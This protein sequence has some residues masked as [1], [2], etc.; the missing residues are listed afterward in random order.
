MKSSSV[1]VSLLFVFAIATLP[2]TSNAAPMSSS[3]SLNGGNGMQQQQN[4]PHYNNMYPSSSEGGQFQF[5]QYGPYQQQQE[6][7]LQK[8]WSRLEPSIR[9]FKR[10]PP[11]Q[12]QYQP[13][14]I[15]NNEFANR[16]MLY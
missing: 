15:N 1:I 5:A 11:Q 10:S 2:F 8:K 13:Q 7:R 12:Q 4:I 16:F 3:S 9:F 6:Q 14:Q